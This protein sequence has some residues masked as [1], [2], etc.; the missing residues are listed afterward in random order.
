VDARARAKKG[1]K[2][3]LAIVMM[4]LSGPE[5]EPVRLKLKIDNNTH[6]IIDIES[7]VP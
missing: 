3:V 5:H 1:I 6:K 2:T 7:A 4:V